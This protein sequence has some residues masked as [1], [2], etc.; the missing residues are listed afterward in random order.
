MAK[1]TKQELQFLEKEHD[2]IN[3]LLKSGYTKDGGT[4]LKKDIEEL[5]K[6]KNRIAKDIA[7]LKRVEIEELKTKYP[8]KSIPKNFK[9]GNKSKKRGLFR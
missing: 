8:P 4:L 1:S 2:R 6:V 5:N 9:N 3:K 7:D